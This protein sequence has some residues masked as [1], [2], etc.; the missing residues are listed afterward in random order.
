MEALG[1]A[2][3]CR[4]WDSNISCLPLQ[5]EP[6]MQVRVHGACG[7]RIPDPCPHLRHGI[8]AH[9]HLPTPHA[10]RVF[11]FMCVSDMGDRV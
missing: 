2:L 5:R 3:R 4:R 7:C 8:P 11:L 6:V 10:H 9:A 1:D